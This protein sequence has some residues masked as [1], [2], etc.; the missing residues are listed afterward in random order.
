MPLDEK[1]RLILDKTFM[2]FGSIMKATGFRISS[3]EGMRDLDAAWGWSIMKV[4][5][6]VEK[7]YEEKAGPQSPPPPSAQNTGE[8]TVITVK[9][10][11]V[12]SQGE[13]S[14]KPWT[15]YQV[16][17]AH[18]LNYYTFHASYT[19]GESYEIDWEWRGDGERKYRF[20]PEKARPVSVYKVNSDKA[21]APA[22][23]DSPPDDDIPF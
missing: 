8:T 17:D 9:A 6:L 15:R 23:A 16:K 2:A 3:T 4:T 22:M 11:G 12:Q 10:F 19:L 21:V 7:L 13:R 1:S 5:A 14:G 18:N 20:I